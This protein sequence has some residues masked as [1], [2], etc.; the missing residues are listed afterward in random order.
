MVSSSIISFNSSLL[1]RFHDFIQQQVNA[2]PSLHGFL[3]VESVVVVVVFELVV[4]GMSF[5]L[6]SLILGLGIEGLPFRNSAKK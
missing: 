4:A 1:G 5:A 2:I 6:W 3:P